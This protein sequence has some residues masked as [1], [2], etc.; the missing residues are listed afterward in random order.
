MPTILC[1]AI[2]LQRSCPGVGEIRY[3]FKEEVVKLLAVSDD[4][5]ERLLQANFTYRF[6]LRAAPPG[7]FLASPSDIFDLK[8]LGDSSPS[9]S[10]SSSTAV[11]E[12]GNRRLQNCPG[13]CYIHKG[14]RHDWW[15]GIDGLS[16]SNLF[17]TGRRLD[18]DTSNTTESLLVA[19]D[20]P[21]LN[22]AVYVPE[23][24]GLVPVSADADIQGAYYECCLQLSES[25]L[26]SRQVQVLAVSKAIESAK[27]KA[28]S[29]RHARSPSLS[30]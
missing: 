4:F 21:K 10:S 24:N 6:A 26:T 17:A 3:Y 14:G 12:E 18:A 11:Q 19:E 22:T 15:Q 27:L 25:G 23:L 16:M 9:R 28:P 5:K 7:C 30:P 1:D 13:R 20:D 2:P 29:R 8:L